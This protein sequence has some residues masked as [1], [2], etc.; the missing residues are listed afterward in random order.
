[1]PVKSCE[2]DGRP[3]YK[4]GESG[5]CY[6]FDSGDKES[7]A[8]ARSRAS[9]QGVAAY[10]AGYREDVKLPAFVIAALKKGLDLHKAGFSGDGLKPATVRSASDAVKS[11]IWSDD[12]IIRAAAWLARHDDDRRLTGGRDWSDPPTPGYTAWLLWGDGGDGK[13]WDW[14]KAKAAEINSKKEAA[15][16]K[17]QSTPAPPEDRIRGGRNTGKGTAGSPSPRFNAQTEIALKRLV[18]G[19][20]DAVGDDKRKRTTLPML[21][22]VYLRGAGAFSTSHRPGV[23]RAQWAFGR[24]RAFLKMLK[25]LKPDDPKYNGP[26][27]DL[28]PAEHPLSSKKEEETMK[29]YE[30]SGYRY[31]GYSKLYEGNWGMRFVALRHTLGDMLHFYMAKE[32]SDD[33][34]AA[35]YI[36]D[37]GSIIEAAKKM[38]E[39]GEAAKTSFYQ[40]M[41]LVAQSL[42]SWQERNPETAGGQMYYSLRMVQDKFEEKYGQDAPSSH[43]ESEENKEKKADKVQAAV[44]PNR[45]L[46]GA[47]PCASAIL[48]YVENSTN[49][50]HLRATLERKADSILLVAE[51]EGR[52]EDAPI[53]ALR[54]ALERLRK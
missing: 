42:Q 12:K 32:I 38:P 36:E 46:A 16:D 3:G 20:N 51:N 44:A 28:L 50:A 45:T 14:I 4:W 30:G 7:M 6:T 24:V 21:K 29:N 17:G 31:E 13:G 2:I 26:D 1:M 33:D 49:D 23:T 35:A 19:H 53:A 54:S 52:D 48:S 37:L 22:K 39:H 18:K 5:K 15:G 25:N 11:G 9:A 10:Y 34:V 43:Q 47:Y 27:N 41:S 8:R 40:L